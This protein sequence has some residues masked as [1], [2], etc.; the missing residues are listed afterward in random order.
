MTTSPLLSAQA[1]AHPA[2][3]LD[4]G[5]IR[6]LRE[7]AFR[8]EEA[9]SL[10]APVLDLIYERR[11]FQLMVPRAC[12]GLE[13][14]LPEAVRWFEALAWAEA[15]TGWCVNLGAGA[16]MFAGYFDAGTATA[17]FN[18]S[19]TCCAGSGAISGTALQTEGG[20]LLTGR[21]KYA[22]G[23]NHATHFTANAWLHDAAGT[24]ITHEGEPLFRSFIVPAAQVL[25][26]RNW[27]AIGLRA[28]SSNDFEIRDIFVPDTHV[29]NL[30]QAS[31]FANGSLYRFPFA[32]LAVI[33]M[34]CMLTGIALH[35]MALYEELAEKKKPL[36]GEQLLRD[37]PVARSIYE[38]AGRSFLKA[39]D[40]MYTA[41]GEIWQLYEDNQQAT[42]EALSTFDVAAK[43][44]ARSARDLINALYPLCGMSIL[45]PGTELNKVWRDAMTAAQHYLLSPLNA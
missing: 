42:P 35:F 27:N 41:L 38:P 17:I 10:P 31:G 21:W 5:T 8:A 23:A 20:Y 30:Q 39:R 29:F 7:H 24:A 2:T 4:A 26:H 18:D 12:G 45:D 11:W 25:N 36:H 13:L 34:A 37:N 28:T 15:N 43:N 44:A 32:Q 19:R 1:V 9:R 16:N 40:A 14:S 3:L 6:L 22:S 33:D